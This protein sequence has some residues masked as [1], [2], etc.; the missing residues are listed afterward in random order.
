MND[1]KKKT[2]RRWAVGGLLLALALLAGGGLWR[3]GGGDPMPAQHSVVAATGA[4]APTLPQPAASAPVPAASPALGGAPSGAAPAG[5]SAR[6]LAQIEAQWCTHGMQAHRQSQA[7]VFQGEGGAVSTGDPQAMNR[8]VNAL[9]ALPTTQAQTAVRQRMLAAWVERLERQGDPRS[10]AT[11]LYLRV[12][13]AAGWSEA[14]VAAFRQLAATTT[15]PYVL[16]L[17]QRHDRACWIRGDC[18]A[19][20]MNRWSLIEPDNLLAWLPPGLGPVTL[21]EAQ[22]A[23]V[24]RAKYL[25]SYQRDLQLALLPLARELPPGLELDVAMTFIAQL[26]IRLGIA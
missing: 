2:A 15:D 11:A 17:W 9:L 1:P 21:S 4:S 7:S 6:Q 24:S 14:A 13:H 10:L 8:V 16:S 3:S 19:V 22:W 23:G 20:P 25:R 12:E 26:N 5:L 18:R